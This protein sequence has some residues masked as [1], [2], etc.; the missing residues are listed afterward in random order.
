MQAIMPGAES[1]MVPS[2]SKSTTRELVTAAS[3][4]DPTKGLRMGTLARV[5]HGGGPSRLK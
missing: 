2:R 3:C 5:N 1:V 4:H